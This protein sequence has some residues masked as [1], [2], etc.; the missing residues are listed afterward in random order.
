M[1]EIS[2]VIES[3]F[4]RIVSFICKHT[5][6]WKDIDKITS[7]VIVSTRHKLEEKRK[8]GSYLR[9]AR[10]SVDL[11]SS[12][13]EIASEHRNA[14][15][16]VLKEDRLCDNLAER[17]SMLFTHFVFNKWMLDTVHREDGKVLRLERGGQKVS[18]SYI[19]NIEMPLDIKCVHES[20]NTWSLLVTPLFATMI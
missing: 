17:S 1:E 3:P 9:T 13:Q 12:G 6:M 4:L 8:P 7:S 16:S 15:K 19:L 10:V 2:D 18:L 20:G 11:K 5:A 14:I